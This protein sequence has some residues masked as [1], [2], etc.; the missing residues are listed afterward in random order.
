MNLWSLTCNM[1]CQSKSLL[2]EAAH[3]LNKTSQIFCHMQHNSWGSEWLW[4]PGTGQLLS[5]RVGFFFLF[6]VH[7]L[8][9]K[10]FSTMAIFGLAYS[11]HFQWTYPS[12]PQ[13]CRFSSAVIDKV[14]KVHAMSQLMC[15]SR[16]ELL[17]WMLMFQLEAAV[18]TVGCSGGVGHRDHGLEQTWKS[19]KIRLMS[20]LCC[21]V[22]CHVDYTTE[23]RTEP[24]RW[25]NTLLFCVSAPHG[26]QALLKFTVNPWWLSQER[27]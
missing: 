16:D 21:D 27:G 10:S 1:T 11:W 14:F 6:L 2:S 26:L 22:N 15:T 13:E 20:L 3:G 23:Q 24:W 18:S 7:P 19:V 17:S 5:Q 4:R 8:I 9:F 25:R 12:S